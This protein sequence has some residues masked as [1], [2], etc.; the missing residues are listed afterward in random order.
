MEIDKERVSKNMESMQND[1]PIKRRRVA[2]A[3]PSSVRSGKVTRLEHP[4]CLGKVRHVCNFVGS[5][6]NPAKL[7][8]RI[9]VFCF[10]CIDQVKIKLTALTVK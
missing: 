7:E 4:T 2:R 10:D 5:A 3:A 1:D 8:I 9:H 6:S